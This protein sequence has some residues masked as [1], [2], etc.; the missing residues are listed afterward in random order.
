[1]GNGQQQGNDSGAR[2][3]EWVELLSVFQDTFRESSLDTG[4]G[5]P[6]L[7]QAFLREVDRLLPGVHAAVYVVDPET[8]DFQLRLVNAPSWRVDLER[9]GSEQI[10]KGLFAWALRSGRPTVL[11]MAVG[12]LDAHVGVLPLMTVGT[13]VGVCLLVQDR[14]QCDISVEHLTLISVLGTQFAFVLEN[15]RLFQKLEDQK[16]DLER[17]LDAA[18]LKSEFIANMSHEI[19]TPMNGVCG[20]TE[21]L[22]ETHLSAEQREFADTVRCSAKAVLALIN[23]ILDFSKIEA[24]K[25]ELEAVDFDL[26]G[27]VEDATLLLAPGAAAKGLEISCLVD[28][29]VFRSVR[30]DPGRIRQILINLVGNAIKFTEAGEVIVHATRESGPDT[31]VSVR[32]SVTDTGIGIP[33]DQMSRLFQEFS[34]IDGPMKRQMQG[35][36]LGLTICKRLAEMMHGRVGVES[37]PGR[38]STFWFT[39]NLKPALGAVVQRQAPPF[40][41]R[42][43]GV[44]VVDANPTGREFLTRRLQS[45]GARVTGVSSG[46]DALATLRDATAQG[47][48]Y[49]IVLVDS[50]LLDMDAEALAQQIRADSGLSGVALGLLAPLGNAEPGAGDNGGSFGHRLTKPVREAHLAQCLT[51]LLRSGQLGMPTRVPGAVAQSHVN[52]SPCRI[53]LVED[54]RVNQRVAKGLLEKNG[55]R[56]DVAGNGREALAALDREAY[57]IVFM[58]LQMPEM[59]GY[60]ATGEIRRR[61]GAGRHLPIVAMTAHAMPEDRARCFAVGMDDYLTK[62]VAMDDL[63]QVLTRWRGHG[64]PRSSAD[65]GPVAG[66]VTHDV[67][68]VFDKQQ[69]LLHAGGDPSLLLDLIRIFQ[70]ENDKLLAEIRRGLLADDPAA[71]ER[72][73]HRMKGSLGTLAAPTARAA[74][75]QLE[76]LGR[77]GQ[78]SNAASA[79]AALEQALSNLSSHLT[80]ITASES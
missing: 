61:E 35:T 33:A 62:P 17:A 74:A 65:P 46:A 80:A 75:S 42:D 36:G 20:M 7:L 25:L 47:R 52:S 63:R 24:G 28:A 38:G 19:R 72:G 49:R 11:E 64:T 44:L 79:L 30:G 3:P 13:V 5:E 69:A 67:L 40:E 26:N 68:D 32:F 34:Q 50:R 23:D 18:R 2:L 77:S 14:S 51:H 58:D 41:I 78:L 31:D 10:R 54:N 1:M 12:A 8:L 27:V 21:L 73:A 70:G 6:A 56:V 37:E 66:A 29:D 22:L 55:M 48:A 43:A 16:R 45:W 15:V 53:L 76:N 59:D 57:D 71:V 9:V 4:R 39:A 60:E